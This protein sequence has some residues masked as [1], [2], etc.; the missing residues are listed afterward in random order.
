MTDAARIVA[1]LE[2]VIRASYVAGA[3]RIAA[4]ARADAPVLRRQSRLR[5]S[6]AL[7]D[8]IGIE[9]L[10]TPDGQVK[11]EVGIDATKAFYGRF[12]ESGYHVR[13]SNGPGGRFVPGAHFMRRAFDAYKDSIA[14]DVVKRVQN[15]IDKANS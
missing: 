7:R 4:R 6:G 1:E 10:R 8:A 3:Q 13:Q 5:T 12:Q 2:Q 11:V 14:T 9:Q 15:V